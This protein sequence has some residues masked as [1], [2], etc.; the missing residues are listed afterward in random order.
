[1][2]IAELF[3]HH[4]AGQQLGRRNQPADAQAGAQHLGQ[5]SAVGQPFTTA[6]HFT[7]QRQQ[8]G[9]WRSVE[10]QIAVGV[11]FHHQRLIFDG[12]LQHFFAALQ[13]QHGT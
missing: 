8:A 13:A 1:M 9:G 12:Q 7:A 4:G 6:W 5:R 3:A 11:I 10:V 2:R